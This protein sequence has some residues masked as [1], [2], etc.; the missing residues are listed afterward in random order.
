MFIFNCINYISL[1]SLNIT[2]ILAATM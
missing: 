2:D 1:I